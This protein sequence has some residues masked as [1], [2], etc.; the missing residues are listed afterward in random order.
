VSRPPGRLQRWP[1]LH[2]LRS[3]A[4]TLGMVDERISQEIE[5]ARFNLYSS[6]EAGDFLLAEQ[7][8]RALEVGLRAA[9]SEEDLEGLRERFQVSAHEALQEIARMVGEDM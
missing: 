1:L 4:R 6:L 5:S 2:V 3:I 8:R 9:F 7:W